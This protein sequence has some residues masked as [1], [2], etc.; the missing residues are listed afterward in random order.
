MLIRMKMA[1]DLFYIDEIIRAPE[2]CAQ[3]WIA[4]GYADLATCPECRFEL[5][6]AGCRVYCPNCGF[7]H[8][9]HL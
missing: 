6:D 1:K 7:K 9:I 2:P 4:Q 5:K 3:D 8:N